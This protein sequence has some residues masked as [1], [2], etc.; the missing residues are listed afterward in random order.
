M[1]VTDATQ[2]P[3]CCGC[4]V[5]WRLQLGLDPLA[6][7]PPY[8]VGVALKGQKKN[9]NKRTTLL[10][11]VAKGSTETRIVAQEMVG[12]RYY[13]PRFTDEKTET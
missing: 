2:I 1:Y 3:S 6:W 8:A 5:G 9:K 7:E 12:R 11:F 10:S 13:Y 4:G